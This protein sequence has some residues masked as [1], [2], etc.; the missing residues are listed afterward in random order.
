MQGI[1]WTGAVEVRD[2]VEIRPPGPNDVRVKVQRA[3][4]CHSDVSVV[5]GTIPFPTPVLMGHEGAGE[6]VE[7]GPGVSKVK[8]GDHVILSTLGNCGQCDACDRGEATH[9]RS[10][11]GRMDQPFTVGGTPAFQFANLG[12]FSDYT[13]VHETQAV[14]IPKEVPMEVAC[15]IGCGV[16]TGAGAAINR[17]KVEVGSTC[18]VVGCG[19]IGLSVIQGARLRGAGRIIAVDINPRKKDIAMKVGATDFLDNSGIDDLPAA[20]REMGCPTGVDYSFEAVGDTQLI[21]DCIDMI[22]WGGSAVMIGVPP[23]GSEASFN[24]QS[25]YHNK[26]IMGCRY[27]TS[28]PHHD[29]PMYCQLYLNGQMLLD[30]MVTKTYPLADIEKA[31]HDQHD[32]NLA[33]G[34]LVLD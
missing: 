7:V 13:V 1:V 23:P 30:E 11:F 14:V 17:A 18:V 2:D 22:D 9:C 6:V 12:C 8:V 29:F 33:R 25:M 27:G 34:V 15:L 31:I 5:N 32:G 26:S 4:L 19:G 16:A 3:G 24:V 21:R 10:M 20:I 28:R